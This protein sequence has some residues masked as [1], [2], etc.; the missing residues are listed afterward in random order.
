M[1]YLKI[2]GIVVATTMALM[3]FAVSASATV[4]TSPAG[5]NYTGAVKAKSIEP[6]VYVHWP[7]SL[8][9]CDGEF[10][11]KVE[12][13]GAAVTAKGPVSSFALSN[14]GSKITLLKSGSFE[15]HPWEKG[16]NGKVTWTGPEI[17]VEVWG[18]YD[19]IYEL[20]DPYIAELTGSKGLAG[21]TATVDFAA[22][23]I[24][25]G[26]NLFC[27]RATDWTAYFSVTSPDYLDVD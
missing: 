4:I 7:S 25:V 14:C 8:E 23:W 11:W 3:V 19:C 20:Q 21:K 17:T 6:R 22:T 27:P 12:S 24:R 18:A 5:T 2:S 10:E 9:T 13:H 26:G 1:E 15:V 16:M